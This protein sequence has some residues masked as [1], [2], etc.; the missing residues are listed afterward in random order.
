MTFYHEPP[1]ETYSKA[2]AIILKILWAGEWVLGDD[3]LSTVKQAYYDRRVRELRDED[4]WDIEVSF[5]P[6]REG[7]NRPAYRLKSHMR[8]KG[9]KRP[10]I[11]AQE[12]K[13]VLEKDGYKCRICGVELNEGRNNPQIDHKIPL[14]RDGASE[15]GNYQSVCS[16]CNVIKRGICRLCT[17]PSCD[18]CY[19]AY[20]EKGANNLLLNLTE[21]ESKYLSKLAERLGITRIE[22]IRKII[23]DQLRR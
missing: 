20:P 8:G 3:I 14:I 21:E 17:L 9:I 7:K 11:T 12:R 23:R 6:N 4:G 16:N 5:V 18:N 2:K 1:V 22:A 13:S 15:V 10:H 19:L